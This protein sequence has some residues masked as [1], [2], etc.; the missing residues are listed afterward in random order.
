MYIQ[1]IEY[2][3]GIEKEVFYIIIFELTVL[4]LMILWIKT[5]SLRLKR[6]V[7]KLIQEAE[8]LKIRRRPMSY[9][10]RFILSF[11]SSSIAIMYG[12]AM[13][14]SVVSI[15]ITIMA[16]QP[17]D[18]ILLGFSF[19]MYSVGIIIM[20][21]SWRKSKYYINREIE[22]LERDIRRYKAD[23]KR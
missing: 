1:R 13:I 23:Y 22:R 6:K 7:M 17:Y 16:F 14:I 3:F 12:V 5:R 21:L 20:F 4:F 11:S 8:V 10:D 18:P 2:I 15:F 19:L 9:G